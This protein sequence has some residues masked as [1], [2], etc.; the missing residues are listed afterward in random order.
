M[1]LTPERVWRS[2]TIGGEAEVRSED[3]NAQLL[4]PDQESFR[5]V[6]GHF[7]TGITVITALTDAGPVGLAANSFTSVSLNPPLVLFCAS[8]ASTTWPRIQQAGHFTVNVLD[9]GQQ[10]ISA[11]FAMP[12]IDRFETMSWTRRAHGPV[13]E[14]V[15][16]WLDCTIDVSTRWASTLTRARSSSIEVVTGS[17]SM[18]SHR[19]TRPGPIDL[20]REQPVGP[21]THNV[22]LDPR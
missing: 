15:H 4:Q 20:L 1:P 3:R 6:L 8:Q 16:A 11:R 2:I 14:D 21:F 7:P 5:T 19:K 10:E 12:A 22:N 18:R 9:D 17:C 13:L